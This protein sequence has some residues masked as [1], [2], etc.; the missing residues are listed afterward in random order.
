MQRNNILLQLN[1][2]ENQSEIKVIIFNTMLVKNNE[3]KYHRLPLKLH[4]K[5]KK[6]KVRLLSGSEATY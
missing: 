1:K 5:K 2:I 6:L 3:L 4:N